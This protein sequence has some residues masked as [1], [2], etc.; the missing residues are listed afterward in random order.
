MAMDVLSLK[1][2][3][4]NHL[5]GDD[6]ASLGWKISVTDPEGMKQRLAEKSL[7]AFTGAV[8][9]A[10][11]RSGLTERDV[12]WVCPVH[13]NPKAHKAILADLGI[14]EENAAYLQQ[15]GHCGHGDQFIGLQMGL[16]NG[17]VKDGTHVVFLGAGTGYAFSA[18]VI[19]WGK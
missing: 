4:L 16:A 6:V 8:R 9:G 18:T 1:G 19:R 13:I 17:K 12:G 5:T 14:A 11:K 7:P 10:L 15:Y 3:S 2:G